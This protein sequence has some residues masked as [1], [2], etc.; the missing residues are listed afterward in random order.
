MKP[1]YLTTEFW[2]TVLVLFLTN[3]GAIEVPEKFRWVVTVLGLIGYSLARG[4][5]KYESTPAPVIP[6]APVDPLGAELT[7]QKAIVAAAKPRRK[8]S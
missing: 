7:E 3:L 2:L 8:R 4:L 1:G 5:A 6:V